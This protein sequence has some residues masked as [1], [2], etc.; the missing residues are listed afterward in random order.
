MRGCYDA[1]SAIQM[2]YTGLLMVDFAARTGRLS[3]ISLAA[4]GKSPVVG[5][6]Q[7]SLQSAD[8]GF[9]DNAA[10]LWLQIDGTTESRRDATIAG[11][12]HN[13]DAPRINALFTG[14]SP[15]L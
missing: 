4:A 11:I 7:F 10:S 12:V 6:L 5:N 3:D 14:L 9:S 8:T 15:N 1:A 2:D 13:P